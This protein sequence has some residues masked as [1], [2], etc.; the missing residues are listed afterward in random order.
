M[1]DRVAGILLLRTEELAKE[2]QQNSSS[3]KLLI[4]HIHQGIN[5]SRRSLLPLDFVFR[6]ALA[7]FR[8]SFL[9]VAVQKWLS[10]VLRSRTIEKLLNKVVPYCIQI[11]QLWRG[12]M[13]R[14]RAYIVR[15]IHKV[16]QEQRRE[17]A[18]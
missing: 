10:F 7:R 13:G 1:G 14:Q 12:V 3:E 4:Q 11:Q 17:G 2:I 15:E 6:K 9:E 8:K 16:E 5:Y 18:R